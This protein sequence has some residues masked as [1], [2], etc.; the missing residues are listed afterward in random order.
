MACVDF[1]RVERT[2]P[3]TGSGQALPAAFDFDFDLPLLSPFAVALAETSPILQTKN[4]LACTV[5]D[6]PEL[7]HAL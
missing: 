4:H 2:L 7:P 6:E 5:L 3:S 1:A